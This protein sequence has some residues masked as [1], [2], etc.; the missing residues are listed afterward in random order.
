MTLLIA[1]ELDVRPTRI[2]RRED[3]IMTRTLRRMRLLLVLFVA[4]ALPVEGARAD[5]EEGV[6]L[7]GV[8]EVRRLQATPRRL[9]L[10]DVRSAEELGHADQR[11]LECAPDGAG[12]AL[13]RDPARGPRRPVLSVPDSPGQCGLEVP[14]AKR[15]PQHE[16]AP[17]GH[18][19]VAPEGIPRRGPAARR[20][21]A[22]TILSRYPRTGAV[23]RGGEAVA[24]LNLA[25]RF[26]R[27]GRV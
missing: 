18:P 25:S 2:G 27:A 9:L 16:G 19:R 23:A 24:A 5:G 4:L 7:I 21:R 14:G 8:D 26:V 3:P 22:S 13:C 17:R 1:I 15:V 10:V 20:D 12:T 11:G 6:E